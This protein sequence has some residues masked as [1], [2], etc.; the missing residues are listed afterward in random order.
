M[1]NKIDKDTLKKHGSSAYNTAYDE[2]PE[3]FALFSPYT[4]LWII[5]I[6]LM[7]LG[8]GMFVSI[9]GHGFIM[10]NPKIT[11][12]MTIVVT[13]LM[14]VPNLLVVYGLSIGVRLLRAL[15]VFYI[16]GAVIGF[17][18]GDSILSVL[19]FISGFL[20]YWIT[21]TEKFRIFMLHRVKVGVWRREQLEK[22]KIRREVIK[23]KKQKEKLA[24]TK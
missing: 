8:G 2:L 12:G 11:Y 15:C 22:N 18:L 9:F 13:L 1:D 24:R 16:L 21:V 6:V 14:S 10:T 4:W 23:E 19:L 7:M 5:E 20:V 3:F 17:L